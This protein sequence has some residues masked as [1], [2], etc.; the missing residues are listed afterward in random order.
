M[1]S[2]MTPTIVVRDAAVRLVVGTPG[3][4]RIITSVLQVVVNVIDF[5]FDLSAAIDA[6]RIHHQWRPNRLEFERH[7]LAPETRRAL[8][9]KGH[10]LHEQNEFCSVQ[11]ILRHADGRLEGLGDLRRMG[12]ASGY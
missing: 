2:S 6:P 8:E 12:F 7:G 3:G 4:G 10:R 1:L 5:D 11:A 9:Q